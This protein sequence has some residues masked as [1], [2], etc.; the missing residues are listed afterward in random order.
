M[1]R[2]KP[3]YLS[4]SSLA[5]FKLDQREYYLRYIAPVKLPK[6]PQTEAMAVGSAF[7]AYIKNHLHT[8]LFGD[9]DP[10]FKLDSIFE[11]QVES[12]HRDTCKVVGKYLFDKYIE[13]GALADMMID[14]NKA[15][16]E[17]R[18]ELEIKGTISGYREGVTKKEMGVPIL[19]K[20]D[21]RFINSEGGH[22]VWDWKV[23][24]WYSKSNTSPLAGYIM[25][26]QQVG[27]SDWY[28][29]GAHKDC[30]FKDVHGMSINCNYLELYNK[31]WASQLATYG[32][33][34][35][36]PVGKEII[37]GVDQIACNGAKRITVDSKSVPMLR[38]ASHR[39]RVSEKFQFNIMAEYQN[40][41]SILT[42]EPF[43]F[44]RD[45]SL[46]ESEMK[47]K[48]LDSIAGA[49]ASENKTEL[50]SWIYEAARS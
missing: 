5:C 35:G 31:D 17:P 26:R 47:C 10:K 42:D 9:N 49:M 11:A 48:A 45:V 39:S 22:V 27:D 13:S 46:E 7:D 50:E 15:V 16:D 23:N 36:E 43:Y 29:K 30:F 37:I 38:I 34:M 12:Q 19:G 25:D 8:S 18:F 40:L 24:G 6:Y 41:W 2:R 3:E 32:W 14:L 4:P 21:I 33:L 1:N 20:P 44:F 28:R